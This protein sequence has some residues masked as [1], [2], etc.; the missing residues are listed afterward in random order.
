VFPR[1]IEV[2]RLAKKPAAIA[3]AKHISTPMRARVNA[4][5][6][7]SYTEISEKRAEEGA[8]GLTVRWL[9]DEKTGAE[10]FFMR[11]FEMQPGGWSPLHNHP[12]E[13][14]AFVL[15]GEGVVSDAKIER[16]LKK[17]HV[18]YIPP[19]E[20]HQFKNN[21]R[22]PLRFLCLIPRHR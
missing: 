22:T 1:S 13:H 3:G 18:I 4:M 12:W 10:N 21:G 8:K 14:E 20:T 6:A 2:I 11:L 5:K 7:F 15:E 16:P 9:I 19:E 17:G